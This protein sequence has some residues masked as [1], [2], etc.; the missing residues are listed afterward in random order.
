M[1]SS[2]A[3]SESFDELSDAEYAYLGGLFLAAALVLAAAVILIVRRCNRS[4]ATLR[5]PPAYSAAPRQHRRAIEMQPAR[6]DEYETLQVIVVA[7]GREAELEVQTDAWS[8]YEMLREL[9]V[10]AVPEM[11]GETDDLILE[12]MNAQARWMRVKMKTPVE[13]VK[14]AKAARISVPTSRSRQALSE[15]FE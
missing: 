13:T 5:A 1:R 8:S 9:V 11:F 15:D 2:S 3:L 12:Y 6:A 14:A 4:E 7:H 10:D